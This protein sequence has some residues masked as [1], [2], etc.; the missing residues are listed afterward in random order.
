[1]LT[2][3]LALQYHEIGCKGDSC[4]AEGQDSMETRRVYIRKSGQKGASYRIQ[5]T[6]I[7][8]DRV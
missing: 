5:S 1:M 2:R 6:T 4:V 8:R 3:L 7:S